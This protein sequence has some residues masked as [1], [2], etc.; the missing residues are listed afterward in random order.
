MYLKNWVKST[1]LGVRSL[2]MGYEYDYGESVMIPQKSADTSSILLGMRVAATN[3]K[4][5][6]VMS[7][8]NVQNRTIFCHDNIDILEGINSDSIDLIYLD[9]P[10]NKNRKFS[11]PMDSLAEGQAFSDIFR[12]KDAKDEYVKEIEQ[13]EPELYSLLMS[14][15][16]KGKG[17]ANYD[18]CYLV[19][20]S[21]RLIECR[22]LLKDTG[23]IYLHCDPL[24]SHYLKLV[25][26]IIFGRDNFLNEIVWHYEGPQSPSPTKFGTK[27][28]IILRYAKDKKQVKVMDIIEIQKEPFDSK[29]YKLDDKGRYYYTIPKGD[30][31]ES[32]IKKLDSEGKVFW[33]SKGTARIKKFVDLS[34]DKKFFIRKKKRSDV[35]KITSLGLAAGSK[36]NTQW[37]TQKPLALLDV[38]V[39]ASSDEGDMILDPFCGCSTTCVAAEKLGR[40]WIG[41]D[42]D[43]KTDTVVIRRLEKEVH[44]EDDSGT[45][46][47]FDWTKEV[48][49]HSVPP[50]RTDGGGKELKKKY[51]YVISNPQYP[52]EYKVGVASDVKK[53]LATYQTSDPNRAYKKEFSLPTPYFN[54]IENEIHNHKKFKPKHEWVVGDLKEIIKTIKSLHKKISN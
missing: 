19:Y 27:H 6:C 15:R 30:Y 26:D 16:R 22:R 45:A 17:S 25:M 31:T 38:I 53:R 23:S 42:R 9:P 21:V 47:L 7:K 11:A 36:E 51:V 34:D 14:L 3:F 32:S 43:S 41:I 40:K 20:M 2:F 48:H 49:S 5:C 10:F 12:E 46:S 54:E 29:K 39:R 1:K 33:N 13:E 28:D 35:W 50:T 52:N 18:Y 24:M 44:K 4:D 8:I 37:K